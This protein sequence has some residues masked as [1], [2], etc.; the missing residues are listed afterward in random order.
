MGR[1]QATHVQDSKQEATPIVS[2][3]IFGLNL[4]TIEMLLFL[5][6]AGLYLNSLKAQLVFDDHVAVE[7]NPVR[8][9][10]YFLVFI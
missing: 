8:L 5:L 1:K 4:E 10:F 9:Y 6:T 3:T 2:E 7:K